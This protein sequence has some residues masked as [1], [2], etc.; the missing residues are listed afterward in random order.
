MAK[1]FC[2][3]NDLE[4]EIFDY[5]LAKPSIFGG[6]GL[7]G[8]GGSAAYDKKSVMSEPRLIEPGKDVEIKPPEP[9]PVPAYSRIPCARSPFSMK[10]LPK[11]YKK[12]PKP[13]RKPRRAAKKKSIF[14]PV[15]EE[16]ESESEEEEVPIIDDEREYRDDDYFPRE[17]EDFI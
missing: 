16:E 9:L 5:D 1:E 11:S 7:F 14:V 12:V 6:G 8:G 17:G 2:T 3:N 13:V 15:A 4:Y 10:V